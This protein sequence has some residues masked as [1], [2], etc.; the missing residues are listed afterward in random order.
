MS[1]NVVAYITHMADVLSEAGTAYPSREHMSLY[2]QLFVGGSMSYLRYLCLFAYS[3]V[4]HILCCNFAEFVFV[5]C[6]RCWQFLWI[7]HF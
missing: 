2:L 6:T 5:L 3:G 7:V 4:L 1:P